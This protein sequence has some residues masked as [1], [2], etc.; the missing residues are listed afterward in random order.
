MTCNPTSPY[1]GMDCLYSPDMDLVYQGTCKAIY[2]G[3]THI[4]VEYVVSGI[5]HTA[6]DVPHSTCRA[7]GRWGC[8]GESCPDGDANWTFGSDE[9]IKEPA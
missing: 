3:N 7:P 8:A 1:V 6:T 5:T 4:D 9:R 2:T